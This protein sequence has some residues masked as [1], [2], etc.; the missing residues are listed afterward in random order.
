M[1]L[2]HHKNLKLIPNLTPLRFLLASF[3]VLFHIPQFFA[4]R[5]FPYYDD[6]PLFH[7][8]TEAVYMFFSLSGFLIIRQLF[9]EKSRTGTVDLRLFYYRRILRIFPLYYLVLIF[10]FLYYRFIIPSLGFEYENSYDLLEGVLLSITF[11]SNIFA[12]Y[13]PGGILEI[14]WSI[15]IE[16]QFY[17]LIAPLFFLVKSKRLSVF[18]LVFTIISFSLY[19]SEFINFLK[20]YQM[21][22]YFFSFSGF[23]SIMLNN[24]RVVSFVRNLKWIVLLLWLTL[25]FTNSFNTFLSP[26]C[27]HFFCMV[28]FGVFLMVL[29]LRS[30]TLL[31]NKTLN[32]LGKISYGIYMYHPIV[33][34]FIGLVYMKLITKLALADILVVILVNIFVFAGTIFI[35]HLSYKYYEDY[36]L[37]KKAKTN[38]VSN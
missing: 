25:F 6:L 5:S 24:D 3:V 20:K 31:D 12:T 19:F 26:I 38:K 2:T 33:M 17:L 28:L 16:E 27:Y 9:F 22:F 29:S 4:N 21:S 34:Q 30:F 7:R 8:G 37:N 1:N 11:F 35:S 15:A 13:S 14:L 18:M 36:F 32:H 23:C 10:G